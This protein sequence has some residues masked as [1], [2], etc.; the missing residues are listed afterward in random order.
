MTADGLFY[1]SLSVSVDISNSPNGICVN[2]K[3][4]E[5]LM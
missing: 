2:I 1:K 3:Y 4:S 5:D